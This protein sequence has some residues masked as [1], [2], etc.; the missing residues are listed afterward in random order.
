MKVLVFGANPERLLEAYGPTAPL[1][2][3]F[4][5]E[6]SKDLPLN[7]ELVHEAI[8]EE[9]GDI[10]MPDAYITPAGMWLSPASGPAYL[11][12]WFSLKGKV[13]S[14]RCES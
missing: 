3:F 2:E 1:S 14:W 11:N 9:L 6:S 10:D 7:G 12:M 5:A 8:F 4:I 13:T